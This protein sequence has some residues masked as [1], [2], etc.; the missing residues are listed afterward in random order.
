MSSLEDIQARFT[1][2]LREVDDVAQIVLKGHLVMESL[3]TEAIETF[4]LHGEFVD[5]ARLQVHQ[6]IA[7]CKGISVSDQSNKM[8]DLVSSVNSVRNALS[9]SLDP[10]RRSK[11]IQNLRGVYEQQFKDMPDSVNG[12]PN[13]IEKNIP[14]DTALCLYAIA[15]SLGYLHAHLAEVRR[16]KSIIVEIDAV[17]NGGALRKS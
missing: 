15:A 7:L 14:A 16:L 2:E 9:H 5:A 1:D 4:L 17:M 8:W 11:A 12:I 3:M 10:N 13:G 6:K